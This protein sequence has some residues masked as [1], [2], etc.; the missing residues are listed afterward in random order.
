MLIGNVFNSIAGVGA[1]LIFIVPFA[2][3]LNKINKDLYRLNTEYNLGL[4]LTQNKK[5][6]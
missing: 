5:K 2:L 1:A 4:K 3:Y 6:V